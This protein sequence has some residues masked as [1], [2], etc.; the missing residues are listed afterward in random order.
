[1]I[2]H[3]TRIQIENFH[4]F[5]DNKY[6]EDCWFYGEEEFLSEKESDEYENFYI[7]PLSPTDEISVKTF[8]NACPI[9]EVFK[10][11]ESN[12]FFLYNRNTRRQLNEWWRSQFKQTKD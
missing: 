10:D 5:L 1:M 8:C 9:I 6:T 3:L 4:G 2:S 11:K 12:N 7:K